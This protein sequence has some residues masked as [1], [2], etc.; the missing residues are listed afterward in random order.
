MKR[1]FNNPVVPAALAILVAAALNACGNSEA[2]N[3]QQQTQQVS[4]VPAA[5]PTSAADP[6]EI[7]FTDENGKVVTVSSLKGKVVF[8]NFWAT[9]CPP[10][11]EEM[12]SIHKLR[13]SY[14]DNDKV[15]FLMV[16]V[17]NNLKKSKAFMQKKKYD[18]PVFTPNSELPASYLGQAIPTTVILTKDG[19]IAARL[20]GGR[21]YNHPQMK[22]ALDQLIQNP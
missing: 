12:P 14:K 16:D 8:I 10:C 6:A 21:D 17:D 20:E 2:A 11:V 22:E 3:Q 18:L 4:G 1:Y 15:V 9:W 13:Q 7:S 19:T 5:V